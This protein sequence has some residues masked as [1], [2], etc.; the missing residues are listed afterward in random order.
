VTNAA[1]E[2]AA[3]FLAWLRARIQMRHLVINDAKALVHTVDGTVFLVSPGIF[4]RYVLEHPEIARA[5]K[6]DGV[7]DWAWV[8]K[9]FEKLRL[10]RKQADGLNIWT[11]EVTGPR[12][13]RRLHGYLVVDS[14]VLFTE[15]PFESLEGLVDAVL[16]ALFITGAVSTISNTSALGSS[17]PIGRPAKYSAMTSMPSV[18]HWEWSPSAASSISYCS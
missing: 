8:Q 1:G 14:H 4:Q 12:K 3:E 16:I 7:A 2:P 5:A 6:Q 18:I 11:C 13:S 10:H 17:T 9:K 15:T